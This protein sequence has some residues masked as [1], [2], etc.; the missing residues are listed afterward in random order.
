MFELFKNTVMVS[1]CLGVATG[2]II[3][4]GWLG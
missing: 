4:N 2:I 3:S 1:Y